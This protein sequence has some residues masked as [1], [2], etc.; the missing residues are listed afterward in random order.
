MTERSDGST[1]GLWSEIRSVVGGSITRQWAILTTG[2]LVRLP[3]ALV[4]SVVVAR[5]LGAADYGVYQVLVTTATIAGVFADPGL[6]DAAVWRFAR[7]RGSA[8]EGAHRETG[9]YFWVR[10]AIGTL[11]GALVAAGAPLGVAPLL[12]LE[13]GAILLALV[14]VVVLV[15]SVNGAVRSLLQATRRFRVL[16]RVL[17]ATTV[18]TLVGAILLYGAG[19]LTVATALVGLPAA[20]GLVGFVLARRGLPATWTLDVPD[21]GTAI[22]T[23]WRLFRF[24]RWL[25]IGHLFTVLAGRLDLYLVS[26]ALSADVTGSYGLAMALA[27]RVGTLYRTFFSVLRPV[28]SAIEGPDEARTYLRRGLIRSGGVALLMAPGLLVADPV[29]PW[30]FGSEF[31]AAVPLF[32]GLLLVGMLEATFVPLKTLF[33]SIDRP[34]LLGAIEGG[35]ALILIVGSLATIPMVGVWGVIGS[36]IVAR[37]G[38]SAIASAMLYTNWTFER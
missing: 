21:R 20:G 17:V 10:L 24:G 4:T 30:L 18:T 37:L 2:N 3:V 19:L 32:Q 13:G 31:T 28:A 27:A 29:V 25:W 23:F 12:G 5:E 33:Y 11:V 26:R 6:N 35:E 16:T 14:P 8:R 38:G 9:A 34:G 22:R 7:L 1:G 36:K 15:T